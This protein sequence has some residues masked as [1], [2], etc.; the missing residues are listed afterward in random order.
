MNV[1]GSSPCPLRAQVLLKGNMP[2]LVSPEGCLTYEEVDRQCACMVRWL[3]ETGGVGSGDRI[4][5]VAENRPEWMPLLFAGLRVGAVLCPLNV[6]QPIAVLTEQLRTLA[7]SLVITDR[8]LPGIQIP[9]RTFSQL[10]EEAVEPAEDEAV[11]REDFP[12][13]VLFTSGSSGEAKAIELSL[14]NHLISARAANQVAPLG[15]GD[16]WLCSLP[17]YHAGGIAI[18]F[19][20]VL[21][22]AAAGFPGAKGE[23][24]EDLERLEITHLSLVPTQLRRWMKSDGFATSVKGVKRVLMGGAP[25]PGD[26][27]ME[28]VAAGVSV[29]VSYGM[30]ETASQIAVTPPGQSPQGA[31]RILPHAKVR[32]SEAGEIQVQAGSVPESL[33]TDGW[34]RTGDCGRLEGDLLFVEGRIDRQFI[35]GGENIQPERI[36]REM[37][38]CCGV[39][40]VV[41]PVKDPEFGQRPA[42]WVDADI[43]E[44]KTGQWNQRLR[45]RLPGYM[46]PVTYKKL[47]VQLG[48]KPDL[49]SL[50]QS[51]GAQG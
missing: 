43:T 22:G 3:R 1:S 5:V 37:Q 26:L 35:S 16:R 15:P 32:I 6:R 42:A 47:P 12:A 7:P 9:V 13:T 11:V 20:C 19:R 30:T 28:A 44:E 48:V 33:L 34:L 51:E 14:S 23:W 49:A 38:A 36:E 41:V 4:A 50:A 18:L 40:C 24:T 31:G 39:D 8:E 10:V 27:L 29:A 45:L 17:L 2:A 46:I 25:M 21:A